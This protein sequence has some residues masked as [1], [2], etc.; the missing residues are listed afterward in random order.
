AMMEL[1]LNNNKNKF[2]FLVLDTPKQHEI[3]VVDLDNYM[4]ELKKL[5]SKFDI[6]VI[7]S[8]TEYHYVCH[9]GDTEW[10]PKYEGKEQKMFLYMLSD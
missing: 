5:C 9:K 2:N 10:I 3:Q 8:T 7:F 1:L 4:K 6:Q